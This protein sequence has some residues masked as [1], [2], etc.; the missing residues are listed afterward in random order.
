MLKES[1]KSVK[2]EIHLFIVT[3]PTRVIPKESVSRT[4]ALNESSLK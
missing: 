4:F 2:R 3:Q 1:T